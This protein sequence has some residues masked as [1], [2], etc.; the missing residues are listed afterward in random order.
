MMMRRLFVWM[1]QHL[2]LLSGQGLHIFHGV[3]LVY[4]FHTCHGLDDVLHGDDA[5]HAVVLV[6]YDGDMLALLQHLFPNAID[7]VGFV[8]RKDGTGNFGK[9][10]VVLVF[11]EF[12]QHH[13]LQD[14]ACNVLFV[15]IIEGDAR[16][17]PVLFVVEFLVGQILAGTFHNYGGGHNF[18]GLH[19]G[20]TYATLDDLAL[21]ILENAFF[22]AHIYHCR[23]F[24][25]ADGYLM[26]VGSE[27]VGYE[28]RQE[29]QRIGNYD[30][31]TDYFGGEH[32]Q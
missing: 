5:A 23:D 8:E 29:N 32:C 24:F 6:H 28:F 27:D 19:A 13:I 2:G 9:F 7:R 15:S 22:L 17:I 4:D 14:V 25:T 3:Y 31:H 30:K 26:F 20:Q 18:T 1:R 10:A 16:E 12:L 11:G 21:G